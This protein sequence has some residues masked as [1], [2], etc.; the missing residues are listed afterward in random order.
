MTIRL[1]RV[2]IAF[3][4]LLVL[5]ALLAW[6][7]GPTNYTFVLKMAVVFLGGWTAVRV[8]RVVVRQMLW[9]LRNRLIVAYLFIALVPIVLITLL[10]GLGAYLIT[11]RVSVFLV[12]SQM[13]RELNTLR[14]TA[15]LLSGSTTVNRAEWTRNVPP[16]LLQKFPNLKVLVSEGKTTWSY[17]Q[18]SDTTFPPGEWGNYHGLV[19][20]D[21]LLYGSAHV[22]VENRRVLMM[23]PITRE[24]LGALAP[25][26]GETGILGL[27][28]SELGD[29][30]HP[31]VSRPSVVAN[32]LPP[33]INRFDI[34]ILGGSYVTAVHWED[35]SRS[36]G[37]LI[38]IRTRPSAVL[39][40]IFSQRMDFTTE[41]IPILFFTIAILF[42]IAELIAMI[43]GV[44][45]TRTI[46]G[47]VHNLYQG[48]LRVR[49]GD[50]SHRI[51]TEGR[52]QLAELTESFNQMTADLK[53]L[54]EVEKEKERMSAELEIAREVQSQLYPKEVPDS[55]TLKLTAACNPA[56]MV[57]GDYY[58]Y[59]KLQEN[60]LTVA[61]G[62]VAG[63]GISAA[64]L[65]ATVQSALRT[66]LQNSLAI[67][68]ATDGTIQMTVSTA[69]LVSQINRHLHTFTAPE[70]YSTFF[71]GV[72]DERTRTLTYTNAGHLP[73]MLVRNGLVTRLDVNGMVVG[74]FQFA[75]YDESSVELQ[76]GD[77]IVFFTD[78]ITEPENEF[79]EM[80]G[81]EQLEDLLAKSAHLDDQKIVDTIMAAVR[82]WTGSD[83][84][85]DDMTLLLVRSR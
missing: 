60:V 18:P 33:A 24:Y 41:L 6:T 61:A 46:T 39:R 19:L 70:K 42:L 38:G 43:I 37:E 35:P 74:A 54:V 76:P 65:M 53:R 25:N 52:D 15:E 8:W 21:G 27:K 68:A 82:Q 12:T 72:Y 49:A 47:A 62:D 20:K 36:A 66:I 57:S 84:L 40:T 80:F 58:D 71:F 1:G 67:Y 13:D 31:S 23:F 69:G 79:G 75:Q 3:L 30:L 77:L 48:T 22:G 85:Q 78:G 56:R 64:L 14:E 51:E 4:A 34:E 45:L 83:E 16:L 9:R 17:P 59:E 26:I 63:K 73:P 81:E 29:P 5:Y 50:F 32:R 44:S 55:P 7:V 28:A 10:A 11:G 2:E